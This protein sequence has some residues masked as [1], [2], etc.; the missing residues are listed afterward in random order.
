[1]L[2]SSLVYFTQKLPKTRLRAAGVLPP[3][4]P[5]L[6]PYGVPR[7][8]GGYHASGVAQVEGSGG[9]GAYEVG[10]YAVVG[11]AADQSDALVEAVDREAPDHASGRRKAPIPDDLQWVEPT[12]IEPVTSTLPAWRSPS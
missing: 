4:Y 10:L 12:G 5:R 6:T 9:V 3:S 7:R 8:P 2:S 1:M 11:R